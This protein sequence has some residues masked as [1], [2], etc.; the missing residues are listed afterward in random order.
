MLCPSQQ[1][2]SRPNSKRSH[3]RRSNITPIALAFS[4][5]VAILPLSSTK[6]DV[7]GAENRVDQLVGQLESDDRFSRHRAE[8]ELLKLGDALL[9]D[10]V[11]RLRDGTPSASV[12]CLPSSMSCSGLFSMTS[13]STSVLCG[14]P[15]WPSDACQT[16]A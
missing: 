10:I 8:A 13:R 11:Q 9:P 14:T 16:C 12:S 15:A 7:F 5:R 2:D 1:N 3:I 6:Q 4:C